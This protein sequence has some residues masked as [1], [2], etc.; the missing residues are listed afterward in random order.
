LSSGFVMAAQFV[1]EV[2]AG[3]GGEDGVTG[4]EDKAEEVV[5]DGVVEGGVEVRR[6]L[7]ECGEVA[8]QVLVFTLGD[9]VAAE[10]DLISGWIWR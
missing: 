3:L 1:E 2:G 9:G 10:D 7:F 4:D 6:G 5:S 8:C